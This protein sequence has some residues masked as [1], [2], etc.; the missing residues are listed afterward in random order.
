CAIVVMPDDD[1]AP[2]E[3][4]VAH[5]DP[6]MEA[7][8]REVQSTFPLDLAAPTGVG[9]VIRTGQTEFRP[10]VDESM[11]RDADLTDEQLAIAHRLALRSVITVPLVKRGHV[12]GALQFVN[13]TWG[14]VYT[15]ADRALAEVAASRIASTLM[16]RRLAEHQRLI[17]TT[18]Q[19]SLL[20][21][22]LPEIDG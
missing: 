5:A 17:A 1:Q 3:I 11:L 2:P 19:Q 20:P 22:S 7:F 9:A 4:E 16:N 21:E 13:S 15:D 12:L 10:A 6:A 14:R 8:A 18:L